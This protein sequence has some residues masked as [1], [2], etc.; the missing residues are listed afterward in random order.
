MNIRASI[1]LEFPFRM[2]WIAAV[3]GG[4]TMLEIYWKTVA[5]MNHMAINNHLMT[6]I[7]K[8]RIADLNKLFVKWD[9]PCFALDESSLSLPEEKVLPFS[10]S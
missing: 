8:Q 2:N 3:K 9:L 1:I 5:A 10:I 4:Q 7:D 6:S